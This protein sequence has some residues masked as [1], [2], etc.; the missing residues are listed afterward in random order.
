[1]ILGILIGDA[2]LELFQNNLGIIKNNS[3][4]IKLSKHLRNNMETK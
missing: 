3:A 2:I 4:I 1:M